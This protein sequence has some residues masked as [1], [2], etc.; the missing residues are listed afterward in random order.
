LLSGLVPQP[1][2]SWNCWELS[3]TDYNH[4]H[5]IL[6]SHGRSQPHISL[7]TYPHCHK[8]SISSSSAGL[9]QGLWF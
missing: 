5:W 2:S 3:G 4:C 7:F 8:I 6:G 1:S 9:K